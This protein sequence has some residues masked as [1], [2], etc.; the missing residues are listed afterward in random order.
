MRSCPSD[1]EEEEE[2]GGGGGVPLTQPRRREEG[3][4]G[5]PQE[6][7]GHRDSKDGPCVRQRHRQ[8]SY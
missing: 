2:E 7:R 5:D 4:L 1:P 6:V 8:A 3:P